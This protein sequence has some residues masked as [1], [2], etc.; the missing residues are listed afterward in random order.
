MSFSQ[1]SRERLGQ[2]LGSAAPEIHSL[3]A[4][5]YDVWGS[6]LQGQLNLAMISPQSFHVYGMNLARERKSIRALLAAGE[7]KTEA[8][9]PCASK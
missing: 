2:I 4:F 8:H 9:S 1:I 6:V 7:E 3:H 5:R